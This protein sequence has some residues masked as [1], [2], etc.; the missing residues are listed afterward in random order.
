MQFGITKE[1]EKLLDKNYQEA[2][3]DVRFE[4]LVAKLKWS[5]E[6]VKSRTTKLQ[7]TLEELS[8]CKECK[9]LFECKNAYKGHVSMPKKEEG[10]IYFT[11]LPCKYT[12]KSAE[13]K[14]AKESEEKIHERARMKD[15][16]NKGDKKRNKVISWIVHF[17]NDYDAS[18]TMKGLYLH[19]NFGC[20]KTFL[21][22][23]LFHELEEKKNATIEIVYFPEVLRELKS[24]WELYDFKMKYYQSVDLLCIDDIG[25]EK[26]SEW[27][28][29]EVLA[30][31]LQSRMEQNLTTFFTSNLNLEELEQHFLMSE[32][33]DEKM[34]A[35][36]IMERIK[37]LSID[38]EM[39]SE[40]RRI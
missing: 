39:I 27:G 6:E 35:R 18:K 19:G 26:V 5:E 24:D 12:K 32:K 10:R 3:K 36:R 37:Q 34:K 9:G 16:D 8:H 2:L 31:I 1:Q 21:V 29:D 14:K 20:G 30:T 28:R 23:A 22:S 13:L 17:Y 11:Y 40:N 25:A 7:D 38:M 15:I 4:R 33:G